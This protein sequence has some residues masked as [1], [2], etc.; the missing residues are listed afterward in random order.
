MVLLS[1][2]LGI[3][4]NIFFNSAPEMVDL[5][6]T[7]ATH[8]NI[9]LLLWNSTDMEVTIDN[10]PLSVFSSLKFWIGF[11]MLL[12]ICITLMGIL[13]TFA[14]WSM[15]SAISDRN[16]HCLLRS[17]VGQYVTTLSP[18]LVVAS[19]YLFLSWFLLFV[20]ELVARSNPLL[21][22]LLIW[23]G[24][25]F[26]S[27]VVPLSVFGRLVLHT[28]AMA[29][30]P[31]LSE[32]LEKE[33]MPNGLHA[34]LVIRAHHQ[35]RKNTSVT[36]QYRRRQQ[37]H[38]VPAAVSTA[39][40]NNGVPAPSSDV[41]NGLHYPV[42]NYPNNS[43][44][45]MFASDEERIEA[46]ED[47]SLEYSEVDRNASAVA[48]SH[49]S[50]ESQLESSKLGLSTFRRSRGVSFDQNDQTPKTRRSARLHRR[51]ETGDTAIDL[52]PA[53][54]LNM[55]MTGKEFI[56]LIN[57][58]IDTSSLGESP[59]IQFGPDNAEESMKQSPSS[60][61]LSH[62]MP[63]PY[64]MVSSSSMERAPGSPNRTN[65]QHHRRVSSSRFLLHEW[66]QENS[67]RD[68]YGV[69]P[70][71]EV[72][73]EITLNHEE[74]S[75][76]SP[77]PSRGQGQGLSSMWSPR[78]MW[79][80][81]TNNNNTS[82]TDTQGAPGLS[83]ST[84]NNETNVQSPGKLCQPLLPT[85]DGDT[86]TDEELGDNLLG[87]DFLPPAGEQNRKLPPSFHRKSR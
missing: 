75:R 42:F 38:D 77:K 58:A 15:I 65:R 84:M 29:Q 56:E 25:M 50:T 71:A 6:Q 19:V 24:I 35:Q 5:R 40:D 70:P 33:L 41:T 80:R 7:L 79:S 44:G 51:L 66:A 9:H 81:S 4:N 10:P 63:P 85:L 78:R 86:Y 26:F 32:D 61:P 20:V 34:S 76:S 54:V 62:G 17:S 59:V 55:S 74:P 47:T 46:F 31:V 87:E 2:L 23:V 57:N 72:P 22:A 36:H 14:T 12:N 3:Q 1:L 28:G 30:R 49:P 8:C 83:S 52:P 73:P 21:W 48:Y 39:V 27:I 68:L 67:I 53:A 37:R 64:P 82:I 43:D 60:P 18:R 13:A 69:A 45:T 11:L 16:A